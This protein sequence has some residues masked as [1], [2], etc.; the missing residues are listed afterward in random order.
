MRKQSLA[1]D[2]GCERFIR[3]KRFLEALAS[4]FELGVYTLNYDTVALA[5][6]PNSFTGF[7]IGASR[8]RR[9]FDPSAIQSRREWEFVYHLHGSVHHSLGDP[10][11]GD[12]MVEEMIWCD[13]LAADFVDVVPNAGS[14]LDDRADGKSLRP[15]TLV[16]GGHKLDQLLVE[17]FQSL[18]AALLRHIHEA[19]AVIIGGY[20]FRD[21]HVDRALRSR[22]RFGRSRPRVVVL[23]LTDERERPLNTRE[24]S[25]SWRLRK[26]LDVGRTEFEI[27]YG[28]GLNLRRL[29]ETNGFEVA[30]GR[31]A[32]WHNGFTEAYERM[33]DI[34]AWLEGADDKVLNP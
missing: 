23:E 21:E 34:A 31:V 33:N 3:Y 13:D 17:P 16:A 27:N 2:Q 9:R 11:G 12:P 26:P 4:R 29:K 20:G 7:S 19:D 8:G 10:K 28:H 1:L 18:H 24:D 14:Y 30:S 25:W 5:A 15:T 6:L 32:V 22:M